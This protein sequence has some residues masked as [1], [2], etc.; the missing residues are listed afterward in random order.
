M[1]DQFQRGEPDPVLV[2]FALAKSANEGDLIAT[3]AASGVGYKAS[4]ETWNTDLATTRA[5]FVT[6]FVGPANQF[7]DA[8]QP[9]R[10]M[11]GQPDAPVLQ[12]HTGGVREFDAPAAGTYRLGTLVGVAKDTGNALTDQTL[13]VVSTQAQAIGY[14]VGG[15]GVNPARIEVRILSTVCPASRQ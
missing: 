4:E 2:P 10:G 6:R 9:V 13:E 1:P 12:V 8:N 3:V 7:K 11:A 15:M 14:V 5:A